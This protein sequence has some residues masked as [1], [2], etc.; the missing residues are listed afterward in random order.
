MIKQIALKIPPN[1]EPNVDKPSARPG[2]FNFVAI[3]YPSRVVATDAGVPGV[4]KRIAEMDPPYT[5]EHQDSTDS[6]EGKR[7]WKQKR[8]THVYRKSRHCSNQ[9]TCT[10]SEN[11]ACQIAYRKYIAKCY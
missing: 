8:N 1:V 9:D 4:F 10:G 7:K 5:K 3:G 6:L 11:K 2:C